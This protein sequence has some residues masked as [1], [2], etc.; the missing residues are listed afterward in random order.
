MS[1][2]E[3]RVDFVMCPFSLFS[4]QGEQRGRAANRFPTRERAG[5]TPPRPYPAFLFLICL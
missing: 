1:G 5:R 2:Q 3:E 4:T